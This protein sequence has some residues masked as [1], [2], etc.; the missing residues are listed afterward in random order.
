[1]NDSNW[2]SQRTQAND[3]KVKQNAFLCFLPCITNVTIVFMKSVCI[4][5]TIYGE[6]FSE[7]QI[8]FC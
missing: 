4:F 3:Y 8:K 2:N 5:P 7:Y 1:M 6:A